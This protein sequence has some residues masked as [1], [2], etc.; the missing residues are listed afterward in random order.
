MLKQFDIKTYKLAK[1]PII[2]KT[3]VKASLNYKTLKALLK[4]YRK[5]K[6]SLMHL[7]IKTKPNI[8]Y[9]VS[10]LS[11][12]S[13]NP[14]DEHYTQLK[15][16]LRYIKDTTNIKIAYKRNGNITINI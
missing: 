4:N 14:I 2:K 6:S 9:A 15:Q 8:C 11:Q 13:N 1:T 3:L 16:I 10:Q 12:F 7:I 5:L